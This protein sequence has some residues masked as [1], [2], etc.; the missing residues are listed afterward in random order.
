MAAQ[1]T[2]PP[3][4]GNNPPPVPEGDNPPI[5]DADLPPPIPSLVDQGT[6]WLL[7]ILR[8]NGVDPELFLRVVSTVLETRVDHPNHRCSKKKT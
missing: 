6:D 1:P 2:E 3:E 4:G 7:S 8:V 5:P